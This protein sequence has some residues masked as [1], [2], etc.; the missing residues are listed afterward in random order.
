MELFGRTDL[1]SEARNRVLRE[2]EDAGKLRGIRAREERLYHLALTAVEILN[3]EGAALL[4]K[5][6]GH[7]YTLALPTPLSR[8]DQRFA[9][10]A[11]AIAELIRRCLPETLSR[12]VLIAAL[13]NP[14]VTPDALGSLTAG[15]L[16]VT[17]HLKQRGNPQFASFTSTLLCRTGVLGTTGLESA[18][19]VRA[20]CD[21]IH[22][23]CVI[24]VD[25][26]AG[27]ELTG[28]CRSVQICNTGIAPGSGVGNDREA[29]N[30][31]YL[32]VPVIA[33]GVPTVID[34]SAL[35]QGQELQDLFVTPR[36]IDSAV[37]SV[38]R[39]LAYGINLALHKGLSLEDIDLLVG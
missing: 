28:L 26:L 33:I 37:R 14:D 20:L 23:D 21:E 31:A 38:A 34:A 11:G 22:P 30:E 29:L 13:G 17:R 15:N 24:A 7:Y 35:S 36:F 16:L 25:A 3:E 27:S 10:A 5:A 12:G 32:G 9:D 6:P 19:Q 4:G 8:G 39:V 1:A 2:G 18:A